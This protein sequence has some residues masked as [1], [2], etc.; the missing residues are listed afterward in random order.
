[1]QEALTRIC[2]QVSDD[3]RRVKFE[4]GFNSPCTRVFEEGCHYFGVD[5]G[6]QMVL[7]DEDAQRNR[8]RPL[9]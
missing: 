2:S 3:S 8:A 4:L 9:P 1:M 7:H 6:L 5:V